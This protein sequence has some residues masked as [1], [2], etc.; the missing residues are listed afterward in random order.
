MNKLKELRKEK[1][2]L[3][4][5]IAKELNIKNTTYSNWEVGVSEPDIQSLTRLA[6]FFGCSID[7]LVGREDEDGAFIIS[8]NTLSEDEAQLLDKLRQ[9]NPLKK[10]IA[11]R[12]IDFLL[13]EQKN[14]K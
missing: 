13:E 4:K 9:L 10:E 11:Y 14:D 1:N 5:D 8:G 6:D 12:Y 2:L 7:Y 3:Q